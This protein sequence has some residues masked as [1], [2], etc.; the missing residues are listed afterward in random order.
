M[1]GMGSR[2]AKAGYAQPK[3]EIEVLG[4]P[5]F[6]WS[7]GALA[8]FQREGWQFHFAT[9]K[10][11][12]ALDFLSRRCDALSI[13]MGPILELDGLTDGQATTALL[14]AEGAN[15]ALPFLV[16][17]IDTYVRPDAM[18][19]DQ[20]PPGAS[21]W[22][23]CFPGP[24]ES[25]SFARIDQHGRALELREK[26]RISPHATVGLYWFASAASYISLYRDF[27]GSG[28]E[29]MGERYIAPM[30]NHLIRAGKHVHVS[31][32]NSEDVGMLGTPEQ[33]A[34]FVRNASGTIG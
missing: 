25:W 9:R 24:G 2:F 13:A 22:V 4:R 12:S 34:A 29:E 30:Y 11:T 19:P 31:L 3:Y 5:L 1:A 26:Q 33:V 10:E 17:N 7:M 20:V 23:P 21:G 28:G 32:L 18:C 16:F 27:F 14:L 8:A 6:D 15:A